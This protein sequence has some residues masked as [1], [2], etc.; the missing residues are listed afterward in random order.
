M[1][2]LQRISGSPARASVGP[3][4]AHVVAPESG[5]CFNRSE[6][7]GDLLRCSLSVAPALLGG[8][9]QPR[10]CPRRGAACVSGGPGSRAP[11]A[12]PRHRELRRPGRTAAVRSV[13]LLL[14]RIVPIVFN[15]R[16]G[17][18]SSCF[19]ARVEPRI[20]RRPATGS[21]RSEG[22]SR[23]RRRRACRLRGV[24]APA[25]T[26]PRHAAA[27]GAAHVDPA[28]SGA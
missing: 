16:K 23:S 17:G 11:P 3:P 8:P 6:P 7:G 27:R 5:A 24:R 18:G 26:P 28:R 22:R 21:P 25:T 1:R 20:N 19:G 9:H 12:A 10:L 14:V 4:F 13:P 2:R 15:R